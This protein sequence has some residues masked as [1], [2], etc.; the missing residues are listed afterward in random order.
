MG[1]KE[2]EKQRILEFVGSSRPEETIDS[3]ISK[4]LEA[5]VLVCGPDASSTF[6]LDKFFEMWGETELLD[7]NRVLLVVGAVKA[8]FD[9]GDWAIKWE[10]AMQGVMDED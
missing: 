6:L 9:V 5:V 3:M 1:I 4:R 7:K 8:A 2:H 10:R